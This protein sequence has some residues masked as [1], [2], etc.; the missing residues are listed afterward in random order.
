MTASELVDDPVLAHLEELS[1]SF[2]VA[3]SG[4]L[5][6]GK[7]PVAA[8]GGITLDVFR[9]ETLGVVGESGSGKSTLGKAMLGMQAASTGYVEFDGRKLASMS[10]SEI[11]RFRRRAQMIFQD[12]FSSLDP[13]MR[14][15][16]LVSEPFAIHG[17]M[18]RRS[19]ELAVDDLLRLVAVDP[20]DKYRY[21]HQFS[22]GQRQRIG[23]AQALAVSPEFIVCDE[24]TSALDVSVQAQIL[25]LLM[26]LK[27]RLN[28]TMVFISHD[29][30]TV[31][32]I[33]D[34]VAVLH[35]GELVEIGSADRIFSDPQHPYT[36]TLL[37]SSSD[38]M[39]TSAS[40]GFMGSDAI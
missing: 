1:V 34:R 18:R 29:L 27:E 15:G 14:V 31:R 39:A 6:K 32:V 7:T 16:E 17:L 26:D 19:R 11:Q 38:V 21:P 8:L 13:R 28:L 25:N 12:P 9:G 5:R 30:A 20:R 4:R 2:P 37:A 10:D 22:G 33:S 24:P 3:R 23:I 35:K 40:D 36:R